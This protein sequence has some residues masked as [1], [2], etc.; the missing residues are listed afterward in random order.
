MIYS[1]VGLYLLVTI[2]LN[3]PAVQHKLGSWVEDILTEELS[4][5]VSVGRID[6][7]IIGRLVIDDVILHD[8][9][10]E[11]ALRVN[12]LS[13][14]FSLPAL[15]QGKVR[16]RNIQLYSFALKVYRETENA[17][18]NIDF[19][20]DKF[21]KQE[22]DKE[23]NRIDLSIA[24]ITARRGTLTYD[25]LD[26]PHR[27]K[28]QFD[29][30][31]INLSGITAML[32]I[33]L[34]RD[35][36]LDI[37]A[38]NIAF[39]EQSGF[40]LSSLSF[41]LHQEGKELLIDDIR[42]KL[43]RSNL[44]GHL[45]IGQ[46]Y[47][48][49][50]NEDTRISHLDIAPLLPQLAGIPFPRPLQLALSLHGDDEL[51][52]VDHLRATIAGH[53]NLLI[54]GVVE[55][56]KDTARLRANLTNLTLTTQSFS[57]AGLTQN[58][59]IPDLG[60]V[61]LTASGFLTYT[62]AALNVNLN[63]E[64]G[65]AN[66]Q[67]NVKDDKP[68]AKL[69]QFA[70]TRLNAHLQATD[71]QVGR[72][73]QQQDLENA[74]LDLSGELQLANGLPISGT[75]KGSLANF[76][77]KGYT[78]AQANVQAELTRNKSWT[79]KFDLHD[80][81]ATLTIVGAGVDTHSYHAH[82][83]V[84][85]LNPIATRLLEADSLRSFSGQY[86]FDLDVIKKKTAR[87]DDYTVTL[88]SPYL[89][90]N[91]T[92]AFDPSA[93]SRNMTAML[94][95]YI[96]TLVEASFDDKRFTASTPQTNCA[97]DIEFK[98]MDTLST[99]FNLPLHIATG[100]TL[101][102]KISTGEEDMQ[103]EGLFPALH[104]ANLRLRDF[105]LSLETTD[106]AL[107]GTIAG[108]MVLKND[109][110]LATHISVSAQEDNLLGSISWDDQLAMHNK[111]QINLAADISRPA[112]T[113]R[114][115]VNIHILPS[116]VLLSDSTW[117][118]SEATI[119]IDTLVSVQQFQIHNSTQALKISG[120]ASQLP[121]DSVTLQLENLHLGY[122]F[123]LLNFHPVKFDGFATGTVNLR[124][125]LTS[126][127]LNVLAQVKSF[128][129]NDAPMGDLSAL[130]G[131]FRSADDVIALEAEL[132][133]T[134]T[135][136]IKGEIHP[137]RKGLDLRIQ[138]N[139]CNLGF[140]Q[141]YIGTIF[142][143]FHGQAN[144]NFRLFGGFETL[145]VEGNG[146]VDAT[147]RID[148]LGTRY[149]LQDNIQITPFRFSLSDALISDEEGH[150]GRITAD[151]SH[152]YFN[153]FR[154]SVEV[155]TDEMILMNQRETFTVPFYGQVYG[156]GIVR[157]NGDENGLQIDGSITTARGTN[158][159]YKLAGAG[160]VSESDFLQFA[161]LHTVLAKDTLTLTSERV[162]RTQSAS[163]P[164]A[165]IR[166]NLP[167][168]ITPA[169]RLRIIV[170]ALTGDYITCTGNGTLRADYHNDH[171]QLNGT[172]IVNEGAYKFS[173][174]NV[175]RKDFSLA[176]GSSVTFT[177]VPEPATANIQAVYTVPSVSLRD[178][179]SDV[180][181]M[182]PSSQ[183]HVR[184]N[185]LMDITGTFSAP[186]ISL[187]ISLPNENEE[188]ERI[189]RNYLSTEEE[190]NTQ[191]LY[192][193]GIGRF[194]TPDHANRADGR[195][196]NAMSSVLSST[197]SGQLNSLLSSVINSDQWNFGVNGSTGEA[198][199]TDMEL[200]GML[201]GSLLDNKLLINGQFGY[202]DNS[203][204]PNAQSNFVGDFDIEY[205]LTRGGGVRLRAYNKSNDRYST[206]TTLNTQGIGI[207]FKRD[208][209]SWV[210]VFKNIRD[211]KSSMPQQNQPTNQQ[212]TEPSL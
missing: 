161:P 93:L 201:S 20:I 195:T 107:L 32:S 65:I 51:I 186:R 102:G 183:N 127:I 103:L 181:S 207:L 38:H 101:S 149:R 72:L 77:Y 131:S 61:Q 94:K 41:L 82:A 95:P 14:R 106:D 84:Q 189:V 68:R 8:Q 211:N 197:I 92:G 172:Y 56:V 124:N 111:G 188:V 39:V 177:G 123:D 90:A 47:K 15:I 85:N 156:S 176:Q 36:T 67:A 198:G 80:P 167:I 208:F 157:L 91:F 16:V 192:L 49:I 28:K 86:S 168:T 4:A 190:I 145:Q 122:L 143:E 78:Y 187:D 35:N 135:T 3:I 184:V 43:P 182:I 175:I 27:P 154:Y 128:E 108:N 7:G 40:T 42:L 205:L 174:Q 199:W 5:P 62:A 185:C 13:A 25:V 113:K 165:N 193:L 55:H 115:D 139:H 146:T 100:S 19:I 150:T 57:I 58:D 142:P 63:T 136:H 200:Q 52:T 46:E 204:N 130:R 152:R 173:L 158:F 203:L 137:K 45:S 75:A 73:F 76:A 2:L 178:L 99:L 22:E 194:Y 132:E 110:L 97:F 212:T 81:N 9:A 30:N 1:I 70:N 191:V 125:A 171:L 159:H 114:T 66:L 104:Y 6:I 109:S 54:S 64:A 98:D 164:E 29:A 44:S 105:M 33:S 206:K 23:P 153:D 138:A 50:I 180:S 69:F 96:P 117:N 21:T 88:N 141:T 74:D 53:T 126:P 166:I 120:I 160:L 210:Q 162:T 209:E 133:N 151:L 196:S 79:A 18:S 17:D 60:Q 155:R 31:H 179:G 48:V 144:G 34:S 121:T 116:T 59:P 10:N 24:N 112:N 147:M 170:D 87:V 83:S 140:L 163:N 37:D 148:V 119:R 26:A 12:R 71:L 169:A 11:E 129:L 134:Q 202:R 118:I 89:D